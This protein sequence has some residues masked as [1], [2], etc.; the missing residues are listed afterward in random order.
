[1]QRVAFVINAMHAFGHQWVCQ[2][3]YSPRLRRGMGLTDGEGVERFW[4]RIR[5]L[6]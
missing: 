4:S 3:V 2:L 1:L 5:K 6:I